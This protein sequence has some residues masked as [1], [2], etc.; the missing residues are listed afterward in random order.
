MKWTYYPLSESDQK[1][2]EHVV[3]NLEVGAYEHTLSRKL[4]SRFSAARGPALL[5]AFESL[6]LDSDYPFQHARTYCGGKH[7]HPD[8]DSAS[9]MDSTRWG[10]IPIIDKHL[11]KT[12]DP[13]VL[14]ENVFLTPKTFARNPPASRVLLYRDEVYHVLTRENGARPEST[15]CA[16]R[17]WEQTWGTAVCS[18]SVE[19]PWG[20]IESDSFFDEIVANT[21]HIFVPALDGEGYLVWSPVLSSGAD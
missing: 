17:E 18:S 8:V 9:W 11:L 21:K 5:I 19:V 12:K 16:I 7:P 2:K 10:L 20:E 4:L 15:E 14:C 6:D 3:K 1:A 13:V